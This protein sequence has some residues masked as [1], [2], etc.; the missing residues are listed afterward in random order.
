MIFQVTVTTTLG[1]SSKVQELPTQ[2]LK[3]SFPAMELCDEGSRI[4]FTVIHL[5]EDYITFLMGL[6]EILI[7]C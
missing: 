3:D 4:I 7:S 5:I 2:P 1:L 6:A